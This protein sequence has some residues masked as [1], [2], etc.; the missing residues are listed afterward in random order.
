M[1]KS[2]D[3]YGNV[4][5]I[6]PSKIGLGISRKV[7]GEFYHGEFA[8]GTYH[9]KGYLQSSNFKYSGEFCYGVING[10][11]QTISNSDVYIGELTKS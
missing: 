4:T 1:Q 3:D 10:F 6:N 5:L 11:G 7:N 2:V 9:G 8:S